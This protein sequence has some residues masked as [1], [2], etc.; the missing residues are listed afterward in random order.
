MCVPD[1]PLLNPPLSIGEQYIYV[2]EFQ[3]TQECNLLCL[4][5]NCKKKKN[6]ADIF[7]SL[8]IVNVACTISSS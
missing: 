7:L 8:I 1:A 3:N 5:R 4:K 6:H 2:D